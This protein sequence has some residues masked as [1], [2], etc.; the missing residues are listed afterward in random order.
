MTKEKVLIIGGGFA[1]IKAALDLSSD[2][3]FDITLLSNK[4]AFNYYPT[5]YHVATG[6]SRANSYIPLRELLDGK[7][8]RIAQGEAVSLDRKTKAISTKD[9]VVF[10]YDTLVLALGVVTNY[11]NIPG[12]KEL[13]YGVKSIED[14]ER[15]KAHLHNQLI[16]DHHP[17]LNYVVVGAGPTGIELAAA[18]PEYLHRLMKQ[19]SIDPVPIHIDLIEASPRLL[20]NLPRDSARAIQRRLRK[21]GVRIYCG[22]A[23][24]GQTANELIVGDKPIQ[25][26]TVIWT[27]GTGINPFFQANQFILTPKHHVATDIY[28]QAEDNI[29][30]L[31]D[32]A[33]TPFSGMAQTALRD[34]AFVAENLKRRAE[35]KDMKSYKAV[36]PITIIPAGSGWAAV[37]YGKLRIYGRLGW[38]LRQAADARAY[39]DYEPWLKAGRQW[40]SYYNVED[41]CAVCQPKRPAPFS[42]PVIK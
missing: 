24:Q 35:G 7:N 1:G 10:N 2:E 23:V 11:F 18:L 38:A 41:N 4:D 16:N 36:R 19:H 30:V 27:A 26:H 13:S 28:L 5:L 42:E 39:S 12:L 22:K 37:I 29:F 14:V 15:L 34:G 6:G 3:H 9:G 21:L 25:S 33:N 8:I 20:P 17:D 32:N 40:L 31:G